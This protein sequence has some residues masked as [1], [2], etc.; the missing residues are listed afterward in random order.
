M[1]LCSEYIITWVLPAVDSIKTHQENLLK[2]P[3][4]SH[5]QCFPIISQ[6]SVLDETDFM[7]KIILFIL[8]VDV[9]FDTR[10]D[11]S[12]SYQRPHMPFLKTRSRFLKAVAL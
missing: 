3:S 7:T 8:T 2:Y 11:V 9:H 12:D 6:I 5:I 4:F 10:I 1:Q